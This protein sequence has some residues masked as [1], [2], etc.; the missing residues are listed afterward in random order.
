MRLSLLRFDIAAAKLERYLLNVSDP[1]GGSKARFFIGHG[2]DPTSPA[3]LAA[4]L[5][6][7]AAA[8]LTE[9]TLVESEFGRRLRLDG[10]LVTPNATVPL[11]RAIWQVDERSEAATFLTAYPLK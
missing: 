5:H 7:H 2:F 9:A 11:V 4:A 8:T 3:I 6:E 1:K 10:R